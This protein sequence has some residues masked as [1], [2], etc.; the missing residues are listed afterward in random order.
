MRI[1]SVYS[2]NQS[3]HSASA[4]S[5]AFQTRH[6]A[7]L[8]A[9]PHHNTYSESPNYWVFLV[10]WII[11]LVPSLTGCGISPK[12]EAGAQPKPPGA[13]EK[14]STAVDVAIAQTGWVLEPIEYTGRTQPL[15]DVSLRSQ[16]EGRV[17]NIN[18]DIGDPVKQ[19]QILAQV[20]DA[21]L[22]TAVT[23]AQAEL[24]AL[25]SEVARAQT[26]V[27]NAQARAE[28]ARLELQ[29]A[30]VDAIRLQNLA[31]EG[32]ISRQE[33]E[34]AQTAAAT[35]QQNLQATLK[36][37]STEQQA[38]A[39]AQGRVKAQQAILAQ[40]KERQ[41][42]SLLASPINGVVLERVTEPGNLV[43]PGSELLKLGDFTQV[44]V[45]VR[46]SDRELANIKVGQSVTVNLDALANESFSGKVTRI[47]PAAD[48]EALQIPVEVTI[49]NPNRQIGSGLLARVSFTP[50]TQA[51]VVVPQTA[52]EVG[53][54]SGR[55]DTQMA[56]T[57]Q[58]TQ[59]SEKSTVFVVVE[60]GAE[61]TV[62]ARQVEISDRAKGRVAIVSG[63]K[64]GER[65]VVRTDAPLKDGDTVRLSILSVS[66]L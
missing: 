20:D 15:R 51:Q 60:N 37:I 21:L 24:A 41:S 57:N 56:K 55:G 32:A 61:S 28:Q 30:K 52:L 29:Q 43:T 17:L 33:A 65:F 42:Y 5:P 10:L 59:T 25:N 44:K 27:G 39:A 63:L 12:T 49:P 22:Q 64:P 16:M 45:E 48:S 26:Q 54:E 66:S 14:T 38:V 58:P 11:L 4:A 34:L 6:G 23:E 1:K 40:N 18:V 53:G 19:G 8:H 46:V 35:A 50:N 2:Q 3:S 13:E 9:S 31:Q 7:S 62:E 47:S 36:Q